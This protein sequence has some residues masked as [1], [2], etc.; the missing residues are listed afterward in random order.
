VIL[1]AT[2][3]PTDNSFIGTTSSSNNVIGNRIGRRG[4]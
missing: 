1:S 3:T 4:G 2:L